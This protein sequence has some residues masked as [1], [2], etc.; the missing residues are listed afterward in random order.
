MKNEMQFKEFVSQY[1]EVSAEDMTDE[2]RFRE[3]LGFS[4]FDFMAFMGEL[5]DTFDMELDESLI[6]NIRSRG[7][8]LSLLH[9]IPQEA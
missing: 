6:V 1:C 5:E 7:E 3:D 8:A 9:S 2:M 4:S